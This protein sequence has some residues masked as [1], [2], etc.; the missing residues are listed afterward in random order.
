MA[1]CHCA[2]VFAVGRVA[3]KADPLLTLIAA[4]AIAARTPRFHLSF[5]KTP[6]PVHVA[7]G[8]TAEQPPIRLNTR[9]LYLSRS[10]S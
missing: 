6:P 4:S 2:F 8:K 3:A 1:V 10:K 5:L 7:P 9:D